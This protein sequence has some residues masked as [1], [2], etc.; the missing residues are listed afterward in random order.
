LENAMTEYKERFASCTE[1]ENAEAQSDQF[2]GSRYLLVATNVRG[3]QRVP[4]HGC[5][6]GAP[7]KFGGRVHYMHEK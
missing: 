7:P 3:V 1:E 6:N 5:G 2:S 4:F